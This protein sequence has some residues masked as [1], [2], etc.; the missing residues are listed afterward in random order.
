MT[1]TLDAV[2]FAFVAF[3][4]LGSALRVVTSKNLVHT[5]LWLGMSLAATSVLYVFLAAPF[6]A[7]MQLMLYTGGVL[8][9]MLFGVML[10]TRDEGFMSV[11][12]SQ[13]R[14]VAGGLLAA[15]VFAMLAAAIVRTP[16]LDGPPGE[17]VSTTQIG[18]ALLTE[19][20]LAFEVL[21][22]LLLVAALGAIVLAQ[23][24]DAGGESAA[25][26]PGVIPRGGIPKKGG[27]S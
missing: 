17:N 16:G 1:F 19:H 10:T 15:G 13:G 24:K 3:A 26:T 12:N 14:R 22:V 18:E 20:A 23:R 8:A 11:P 4:L 2:A 6:L 5:V 25:P 7:A 9:L 21:S 27:E